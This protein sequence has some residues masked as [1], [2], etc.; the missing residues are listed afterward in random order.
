VKHIVIDL[1]TLV[2]LNI[3][4]L[5]VIHGEKVVTEGRYHEELLHHSVHVANAT[6]VTKTDVLLFALN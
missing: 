6:K 1:L 4:G 3:F 2:L 5:T